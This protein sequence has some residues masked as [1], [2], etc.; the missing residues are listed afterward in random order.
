MKVGDLVT[1]KH[2]P[3]SVLGVIIEQ[4]P[5]CITG[6]PIYFIGWICDLCDKMWLEPEDLE[7]V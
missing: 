3:D 4:S 7:V 1:F 2:D 5:D 6:K